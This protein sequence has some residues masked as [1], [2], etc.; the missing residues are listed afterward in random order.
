MSNHSEGDRLDRI[1]SLLEKIAQ[2][3]DSNALAIE[4]LTESQNETRK[5]RVKMYQAMSDL[6]KS[7]ATLA[8]TQAQL[9]QAQ[10]D[11]QVLMYRF[12]ENIEEQQQ[13]LSRRQGD[14][15]EIL[16]LLTKK[17]CDDQDYISK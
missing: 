13:Q 14:I 5:E 2:R 8:Q 3:V 12:M 6:A 16:Q 1:E 9:A 15:V 11:N 17:D 10:A 4:A 7:Q